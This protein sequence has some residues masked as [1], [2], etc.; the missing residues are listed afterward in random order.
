VVDEPDYIVTVI[1][2]YDSHFI[3]KCL[4]CRHLIGIAYT[5][6]KPQNQIQQNTDT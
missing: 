4:K 1:N 3:I 2:D 6:G 5:L